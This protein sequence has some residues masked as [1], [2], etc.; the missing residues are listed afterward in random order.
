M[1]L[2]KLGVAERIE[3]EWLCRSVDPYC[4][5]QAMKERL[6]EMREELLERAWRQ[7][8]AIRRAEVTATATVIGVPDGVTLLTAVLAVEGVAR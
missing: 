3:E 7:G 6:Y 5:Q 1:G 4:D 2:L 8:R